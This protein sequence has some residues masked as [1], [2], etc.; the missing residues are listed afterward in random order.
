MAVEC[1]NNLSPSYRP[2]PADVWSLG[3]VLIN[4]LFH[5]NPWSDPAPTCAP[6][7]SFRADPKGFLQGKFPGMGEEVAGYL[8]EKVLAWDPEDRVSAGEFGKW[9]SKLGQMLTP[10]KIMPAGSPR[11]GPGGGGGGDGGGGGGGGGKKGPVR[12]AFEVEKRQVP[13]LNGNGTNGSNGS[14]AKSPPV[15]QN[16]GFGKKWDYET[17]PIPSFSMLTSSAPPTPELANAAPKPLDLSNASLFSRTTSAVPFRF[18][19]DDDDAPLPSPTFTPRLPTALPASLASPTTSPRPPSSL[20][21]PVLASPVFSNSGSSSLLVASLT[22]PLT[23]SAPPSRFGIDEDDDPLPSPTFT[24]RLPAALPVA[25]PDDAHLAEPSADSLSP[26]FPAQH[27]QSSFT[28]PPSAPDSSTTD[29]PETTSPGSPEAGSTLPS[30][31]SESPVPLP[32]SPPASE[33]CSFTSPASPL[34]PFHNDAD[35]S[36]PSP[37][38]ETESQIEDEGSQSTSSVVAKRRKRGARKG[39]AAQA[40]AAAAAAALM[41]GAE[42]EEG[43]KVVEERSVVDGGI[44]LP[45]GMVIGG[46]EA[47][48][49]A[50]AIASQTLARE[51]SAMNPR[52]SNTS[53]SPPALRRPNGS[54]ATSSS[55]LASFGQPVPTPNNV[56][57]SSSS[58]GSVESLHH[59]SSVYSRSSSATRKTTTDLEALRA[60]AKER[61]AGLAR[62]GQS[63]GRAVERGGHGGGGGWSS[64]SPRRMVSPANSTASSINSIQ[65]N[66]S[67]AVT[68]WRKEPA[69]AA[70][71]KVDSTP[72]CP[73]I[74][75]PPPVETRDAASGGATRGVRKILTARRPVAPSSSSS[76]QSATMASSSASFISYTTTTN[77]TYNTSDLPPLPVHSHS[78]SASTSP[79]QSIFSERSSTSSYATSANSSFQSSQKGSSLWSSGAGG[80]SGPGLMKSNVKRELTFSLRFPLLSLQCQ[81]H[82]PF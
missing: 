1:R 65:S 42:T 51:I 37:L 60:L 26:T 3:I 34:Q 36:V 22:S 41:C 27:Q 29:L 58:A 69:S 24:P 28:L 81:K 76:I 56:R 49:R 59:P 21:S 48:T 32:M 5:K 15:Q 82:D 44:G 31:A 67:D 70:A 80:G 35:S 39:K 77:I 17:S 53:M 40:A 43:E 12:G 78:A 57:S 13:R 2:P 10:K 25:L 54:A 45:N 47:T 71:P 23:G 6:F 64:N 11:G 18:S 46:R 16:G 50:L 4:M 63:R 73:P 75:S 14:S 9:V 66:R 7:Q 72:S 33:R 30:E 68:S 55:T 74:S 79:P 62:G 20:T 61:E 8:A 38:P 19:I 52:S